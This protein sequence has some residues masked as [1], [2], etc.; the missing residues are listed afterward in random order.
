MAQ[1]NSYDFSVTRDNL[2][3]DALLHVSALGEGETPSANLVTEAARLLNM[4]VKLRATEGMPAWALKRGYILPFSG[5]SSINTDSHVVTAYDATALTADAASA[6]ATIEVVSN[7][8][9]ATSDQIGIEL[10]GGTIQWTT[11]NAIANSTITLTSTLTGA[12]SDGGRVY[13]YTASSN[14]VQKPI[15]IITANVLHQADQVSHEIDVVSK[16]EYYD[17]GDRT[18]P[19][20]PNQMYYTI[21]PSVD[22]ALNTNGQIFVFPRFSDGDY[23]IEFTY[24]R[25][26]A[27]FDAAGDNPDFP[28]TFYLPLML[29]LAALLGPRSGVPPEERKALFAEAK[30]YREEALA[31]IF[32][33]G[34][35]KIIPEKRE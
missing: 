2:I 11:V 33:E 3:T 29:E 10:S 12:A 1:S 19:G 32:E 17:L 5:E 23:V 14:R 16:D 7:T 34:S 25:P 35:Y 6:A 24:Q 13:T 22:T 28:Q 31:S 4:I 27:D 30:M 21:H 26:F 15:R 8:G 18:S 9:M 20:V